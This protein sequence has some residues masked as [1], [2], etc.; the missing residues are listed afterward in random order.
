MQM[1]LNTDLYTLYPCFYGPKRASREYW[2]GIPCMVR[3]YLD[4][5]FRLR[6]YGIRIQRVLFMLIFIVFCM[7]GSK[8]STVLYFH[9][10]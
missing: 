1:G 5:G 2:H 3:I 10:V 7:D 8:G 6:A 9:V 4:Y